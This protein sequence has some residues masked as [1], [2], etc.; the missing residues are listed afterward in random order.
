MKIGRAISHVQKLLFHKHFCPPRFFVGPR[1]GFAGHGICTF[2]LAGNG[3]GGNFVVGYGIQKSRG[4]R[5]KG[6]DL[7]GIRELT[8]FSL[9][10]T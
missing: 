9:R 1:W 8:S 3:I 4:I 5:D 7:Y 10:N 2:S 6:I